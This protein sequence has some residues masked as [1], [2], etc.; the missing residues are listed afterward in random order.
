MERL[1][2]DLIGHVRTVEVAGV[3]VVDAGGDGLSEDSDCGV[4]VGRRAPHLRTGELHRAVTH[5]VH[6]HRG[7]GEGEGAA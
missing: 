1:F 5:A 7:A 6:G 3:D 2:D 4:E